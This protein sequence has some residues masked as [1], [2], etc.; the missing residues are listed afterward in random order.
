[1]C[2]HVGVT[3]WACL[4]VCA[5]VYA[6]KP[7]TPPPPKSKSQAL[8]EIAVDK[9]WLRALGDEG[10]RPMVSQAVAENSGSSSVG[11]GTRR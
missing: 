11:P 9:I 1:M 2:V 5:C 7:L 6:C 8:V 4:C 10:A 3:K